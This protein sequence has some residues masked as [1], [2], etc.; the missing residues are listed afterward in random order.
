MAT[1]DEPSGICGAGSLRKLQQCARI[2]VRRVQSQCFVEASSAGTLT[3]LAALCT[4]TSSGPS[5]ATSSST[6]SEPTLPRTS[7]GSRSERAQVVGR[8]LGGAV[9][10]E[11]AD[12]DAFRAVAGEPECD[13]AADA[14]RTARDEDV[15]DRCGSGIVRARGRRNLVPADPRRRLARA[16]VR[17]RRRMTEPLEPLHL[18]VGVPA[19]LVALGQVG[20]ELAHA[21]S[22]LEREVRGRRA[23][24]GVDVVA[25]R[26]A[27][28]AASVSRAGVANVPLPSAAVR[29]VSPVDLMLLGTVLLWALNLTVTKY[30]LE[31]GFQP[32]AYATIRYF[33]ATALFWC[34]TY[35]R[36]GSFRIAISDAGSWPS[37]RR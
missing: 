37:R 26:L 16:L 9:A 14:P 10:A 7:V 23:D 25:G 30:V 31:H 6:R 5:A 29:R 17:L 1:I 13:R 34:F 21:R 3:P 36:E 15:H 12:R 8:L 20:D 19:N 2:R 27:H 22:K 4:S 32:L 33:A 28:R 11:V 18:R 24:E 35:A